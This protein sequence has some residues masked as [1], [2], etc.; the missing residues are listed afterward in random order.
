MSIELEDGKQP[1][2]V[3]EFSTLELRGSRHLVIADWVACIASLRHGA[4][5]K[6]HHWVS[7]FY[8]PCD[9]HT[10]TRNYWRMLLAPST[11]QVLL[12][13][14]PQ[15]PP[16]LEWLMTHAL[17]VIIASLALLSLWLWRVAPRFG[18]LRPAIEPERRQLLEHIR[19]CGRY[20]WANGARA[21][22]LNAAR[23]ICHKRICRLRPRLALLAS[24]QRYRGLADELAM[25]ADELAY[26]FEGTPHSARDFVHAITTLASIHSHLSRAAQA[27][28]LHIK[29]Q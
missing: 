6:Y 18:P 22:L 29:R 8:Q 12:L 26:T 2:Q 4:D 19:A 16:I 27:P 23:E 21:S 9:R 25:S 17:E 5:G 28:R 24:E 1:L 11:S 14:A 13:R 3:A 10:S 20:R 7:A 15:A